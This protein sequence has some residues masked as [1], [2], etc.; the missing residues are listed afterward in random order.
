MDDIDQRLY[1]EENR[2][3]LIDLNS[4]VLELKTLLSNQL[5]AYKAPVDEVTIKGGVTV[6]TEKNVNVENMPDILKGLDELSET[7]TKA[8]EDNSHKPLQEVTVKNIKDALP[9]S[10]E[11]TNLEQLKSYFDDVVSAVNTIKDNQPIVKVIKQ[12]VVFPESPKKAIPVRLSDGKS[13][14]NAIAMAMGGASVPRVNG[15]VPVVNPDGTN[16]GSDLAQGLTD[17][18]LRATPVPVSEATGLV[19]K[20]YDYMSY[21]D[22]NTTTDTYVYKTGGSAG[23]TVATVTIV[24]SDATTKSIIASVART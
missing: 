23:T 7:I 10:L 17:T 19:P 16:I 11:I 1:A 2:Q 9:E 6:N 5:E 20:V 13:F 22:T 15:S 14:Y 18:E 4:G 3:L 24:Y 21:T 12:D 8:I